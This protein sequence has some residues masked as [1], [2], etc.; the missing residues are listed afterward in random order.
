M[1]WWVWYNNLTIMCTTRGERRLISIQCQKDCVENKLFIFCT[2][3]TIPCCSRFM[4]IFTYWSRTM[5]RW[6]DERTRIV[7]IGHDQPE[8]SSPFCILVSRQNISVYKFWSTYTI[9]FKRHFFYHGWL[10]WCSAEPRPSNKKALGAWI[11]D[12]RR[13]CI[14]LWL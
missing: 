8:A 9:P 1:Y 14:G 4:G 12:M 11:A 7:I 3:Q 10:D 5:D 6:T 2:I 13:W